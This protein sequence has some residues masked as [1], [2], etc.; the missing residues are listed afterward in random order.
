MKRNVWLGAFAL[1]LCLTCL[2]S[3]AAPAENAAVTPTAAASGNGASTPAA[4]TAASSQPAAPSQPAKVTEPAKAEKQPAAEKTAASSKAAAKPA[5]KSEPTASSKAPA[6]PATEKTES[7]SASSTETESPDYIFCTLPP[8]PQYANFE[9]EAYFQLWLLSGTDYEEARQAA[10]DALQTGQTIR[11]YA[12]HKAMNSERMTLKEIETVQGSVEYIFSYR[13]ARGQEVGEVSI[14][15][16][17]DPSKHFLSEYKRYLLAAQN[18]EKGYGSAALNG[19]QYVWSHVPQS[20]NVSFL[21]QI[22]GQMFYASALGG[23]SSEV[24]DLLPLLEVET[25]TLYP[26]GAVE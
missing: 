20:G 9:N 24:A 13:S 5:A 12:P 1:L 4:F 18:G 11:Y 8:P 21:Y 14:N 25:V 15:Q 6:K 10:L 19:C 22:D 7:T 26:N 17:L 3:C 2:V 23:M 16:V